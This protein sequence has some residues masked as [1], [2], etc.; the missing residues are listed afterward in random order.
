MLTVRPSV[1]ADVP[2]QRELWKLAFGDS[3]EYI[4]N[5]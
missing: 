5:F 4:G 3:D 1:P 2:V